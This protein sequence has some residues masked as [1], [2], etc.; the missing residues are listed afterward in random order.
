M[1]LYI[2]GLIGS[3]ILGAISIIILIVGGKDE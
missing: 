1:I 3:F 2:L